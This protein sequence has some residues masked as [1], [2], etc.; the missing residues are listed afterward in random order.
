[1]SIRKICTHEVIKA[2]KSM[3]I[4]EVARLMKKNNIGTVVIVENETD[5]KPI[6]ILTDRD[7]TIKILAE[8]IESKDV[9]IG[10]IMS[11]DL[12]ILKK[13]QGINEAIEMMCAK[14]VRRAPV[15]DENYNL[16]G[17][18]VVDD[19][20]LL[21]ADELNSLAKLVRKQITP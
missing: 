10:D 4:K 12:L 5:S 19:L 21:I 20:L 13:H 18:A 15:V 11:N 2:A 16:C 17:I 8:D 14:G 1:M 7:L 3:S 9:R 6:G